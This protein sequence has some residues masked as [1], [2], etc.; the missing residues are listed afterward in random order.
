MAFVDKYDSAIEKGERL[1]KISGSMNDQFFQHRKMHS[2]YR[3][4]DGFLRARDCVFMD[5][6]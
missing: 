4:S 6:L 2:L 1:S 3:V 5:A